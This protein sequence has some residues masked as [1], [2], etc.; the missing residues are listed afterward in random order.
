MEVT[1]KDKARQLAVFLRCQEV[2]VMVIIIHPCIDT[3][4]TVG[5]KLAPHVLDPGMQGHSGGLYLHLHI[6]ILVGIIL[7]S[8]HGAHGAAAGWESRR[9]RG[10]SLSHVELAGYALEDVGSARECHCDAIM[11][12]IGCVMCCWKRKC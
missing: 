2:A 4:Y 9:R 10:G 7:Y 1:E 6:D 12:I 8:T 5:I 11:M 3:A